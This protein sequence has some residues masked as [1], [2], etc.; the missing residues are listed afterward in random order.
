MPTSDNAP[1]LSCSRY[2][3]QASFDVHNMNAKIGKS[4]TEGYRA[5]RIGL[6][7]RQ[8]M[9]KLRVKFDT[10]IVGSNGVSWAVSVMVVWGPMWRFRT[11]LASQNLVRVVLVLAMGALTGACFQPLYGSRTIGTEDSVKDR[12]GSS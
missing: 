4:K 9:V 1:S 2:E 5:K 10:C 12:L 7:G 11:G 6:L 3:R 8:I